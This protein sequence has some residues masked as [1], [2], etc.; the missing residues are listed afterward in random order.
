MKKVWEERRGGLAEKLEPLRH[1]LSRK[2]PEPF[3]GRQAASHPVLWPKVMIETGVSWSCGPPAGSCLGVDESVWRTL[4][5]LPLPCYHSLTLGSHFPSLGLS[6]SICSKT[7]F[8]R[9]IGMMRY[10]EIF[11]DIHR[12]ASG[13]VLVTRIAFS[14]INPYWSS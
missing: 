11:I 14:P 10:L 12:K 1:H 8:R 2:S 7:M 13:R 4:A 5:F 6:L 9:L 3:S